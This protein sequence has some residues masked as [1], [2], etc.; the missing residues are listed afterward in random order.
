MKLDPQIKRQLRSMYEDLKVSG[1]TVIVTT[2]YE[3]SEKEQSIILRS[4]EI[5][6]EAATIFEV[7]PSIKAGIVIT[8][9]S[10]R[11]DLSLQTELQ[12]LQHL[13]YESI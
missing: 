5:D 12:H 10:K 9:G 8:H 11:I 13:M 2:P 6:P 3:T 4:F 7:D 1:G